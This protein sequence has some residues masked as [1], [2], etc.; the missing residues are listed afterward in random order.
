[1]VAVI[2]IEQIVMIKRDVLIY[3]FYFSFN[4]ISFLAKSPSQQQTPTSQQVDEYQN[5]EQQQQQ[6]S[7]RGGGGGG[8]GAS[9]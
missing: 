6:R 1:M 5:D 3:N 9:K 7:Y 4:H 2:V 8:S